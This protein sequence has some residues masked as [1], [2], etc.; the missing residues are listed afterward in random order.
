M[1]K[2][3]GRSLK[4]N[5]FH[6]KHFKLLCAFSTPQCIPDYMYTHCGVD[7]ALTVRY[8]FI[9]LVQ[10]QEFLL[11]SVAADTNNTAMGSLQAMLKMKMFAPKSRNLK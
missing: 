2:H 11:V 4:C 7:F 8:P 5:I 6:H 10:L 3:E 1:K 9:F